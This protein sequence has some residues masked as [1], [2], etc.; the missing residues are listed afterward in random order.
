[1]KAMVITEFGGPDVF[2]LREVPKPEIG[3]NQVLVRVHATS[4]NPVDL[5]VRQAGSWA[6]VRP[7][8][9]IGYDVSGV[10]EVVGPGVVDV[11]VGDEVYYSPEISGQWGSYAEYNAVDAAIVARK[12]TNLSHAEAASI[13]LVGCAA[14]DGLITKAN[15]MV[16]ETVLIHGGGGVGSLAVQIAKAAGAFV[17]VVCSDYM[18][19]LIAGLGADRA[20]DYKSEDFVEVVRD[21]TDGLGVDVVFDAVGGDA[22]ARSIEVVKPFGRMAGMV[23]SANGDWGPGFGKN[24]TL[25]MTLLERMAYKLDALCVLIER[26][27]IE[28]VIDSVLPITDVAEAHRRLAAGGVKGKIVLDTTRFE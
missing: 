25:Y 26:G 17:L 22:L 19:D 6:G 3:P 8:A 13:P 18:V 4:V 1:M 2:E 12:P 15:L 10:V 27:Q 5:G 11:M 7:P 28:P 9:V 20:I 23:R 16:G 14:W 24:L 21:E